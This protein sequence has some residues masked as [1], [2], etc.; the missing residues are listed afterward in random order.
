MSIH[1]WVRLWSTCHAFVQGAPVR[2]AWPDGRSTL[3]QPAVAVT[4]FD[5]I[6]GEFAAELE[7][8]VKHDTKR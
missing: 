7:A 6:Q 1:G 8:Q 5:L 2:L 3:R 4:M